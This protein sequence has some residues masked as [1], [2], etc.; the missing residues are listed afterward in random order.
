MVANAYSVCVRASSSSVCNCVVVTDDDDDGEQKQ[1]SGKPNQRLEHKE[2]KIKPKI[3][4][5]KKKSK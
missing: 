2:D 1:V 4:K 5:S 3:V